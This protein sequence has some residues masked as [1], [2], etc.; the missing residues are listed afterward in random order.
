MSQ[1]PK[2]F[3]M[4]RLMECQRTHLSDLKQNLVWFSLVNI[5][6]ERFTI[7]K[8]YSFFKQ[9]QLLWI[10][11]ITQC[12]KRRCFTKDTEFMVIKSIRDALS[13]L[14][15]MNASDV[16]LNIHYIFEY[17]CTCLFVCFCN[18]GE[19]LI[20]MKTIQMPPFFST[21]AFLSTGVQIKWIC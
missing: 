9:K 21:L 4:E 12:Y 19:A 20:D 13:I 7:I 1:L 18:E 14:T 8:L 16:T 10:F 15:R 5:Q 6:E 17:V 11:E 3:K 2:F